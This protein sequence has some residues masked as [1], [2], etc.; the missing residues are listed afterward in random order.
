[1]TAPP[2]IQQFGIFVRI[3]IILLSTRAIAAECQTREKRVIIRHK[4]CRDAFSLRIPYCEGYCESSYQPRFSKTTNAIEYARKCDCCSPINN[5]TQVQN[6]LCPGNGREINLGYLYKNLKCACRRCEHV[7]VF[8]P[9][10][11]RHRNNNRNRRDAEHNNHH[12]HH[13]DHITIEDAELYSGPVLELTNA[14]LFS[15]NSGSA[16]RDYLNM[17]TKIP[18]RDTVVGWGHRPWWI[19]GHTKVG[20]G[21]PNTKRHWREECIIERY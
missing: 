21:V 17:L 16:V 6:I 11:A 14:D 4:D 13:N 8:S 1:M 3:Y 12:H 7:P 2:V 10:A 19:K 15:D 20:S 5:P 18:S 9:Q